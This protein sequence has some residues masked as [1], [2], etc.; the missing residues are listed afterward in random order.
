MAAKKIINIAMI[1]V[2]LIL[3]SGLKSLAYDDKQTHPALTDKAIRLSNLG[4]YLKQNFGTQF[5]QGFESS[6]NEDKI[7]NWL[8]SGST[9]EDSPMCRASNHFQELLGRCYLRCKTLDSA[10]RS[11]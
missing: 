2:S 6:V 1:M 3:M 4:V 9:D 8:T 5:S 10:D 11:R 7:I